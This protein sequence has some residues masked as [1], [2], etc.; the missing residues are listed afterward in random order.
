MRICELRANVTLSMAWIEVRILMAK[1]TFM[2]DLEICD[3]TLDWDRDQRCYTL[4]Q[5]PDLFV[6]V[7]QRLS[8]KA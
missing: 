8:T 2:Y 3:K 1:M 7:V 4:W 6:K 5:K